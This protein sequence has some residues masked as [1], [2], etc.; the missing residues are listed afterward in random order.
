MDSCPRPLSLLL[1]GLLV[2]LW[3]VLAVGA[4][5]ARPPQGGIR[6][7]TVPGHL[8]LGADREAEVRIELEPEATGLELFASSGEVGP[9]TQVKPGV[10]RATYVPPR[11]RLPLEVILVALA[12]GPRGTLDGWSVLPL[13]GQGEA[14]VRTR[15]GA[16]VTLQVG[17]QSFGPVHADAKGLARIPVAVPPGVHEAFFG[18]RRIDLGVPPQPFLH[19]VAERREVRADR[20]ETVVIRLYSLKPGA[21]S[22]RPGDFSVS[23]GTLSAPAG[24]EPGVF[25]L[26][27]TVPPGPA[28]S[29]ELKGSVTRDR[30]GAVHV[31]LT[32]VPGPARHFVMRVDHEELVASEEVR[33][34]VEVSA[35]DAAGNPT[36]AG[37]RLESDFAGEGALTERQAGEYA[38]VFHLTPR[39]GTREQVVLRLLAEG[40]SAPVLTRTLKL[41]SAAPARVTVQPLQ[42][43]LMADGRSEAVWRIS[44][45]DRFGN[46]VREPWPEAML[47]R[48]L[49]STLLSKMPGTYELRYVPPAARVDHLSALDVRVGEVHGRGTLQLLRRR[50]VLLVAPRVGLVTNLGDVLAPSAGLRLE[51]WPMPQWPAVG[52]LLDTGYLGFSRTGGQAAPGFM[53]R[54]EWFDTTLAVGLRTL[55]E[56][57]LQGWVAMGPSVAR[58]RSRVMWGEGPALEEGTWVLGAQA[59]VGAGLPLVRGQPFLEARFSWFDDPSLRVLRGALWG[60]GLHVGYRLELF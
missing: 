16:P 1:V 49:A 39:F 29:L 10:F 38:G 18:K 13:W 56:K 50:P 31:R 27:W 53:G 19:A 26:R 20:E 41:R 54:N 21:M 43:M 51:A 12:R 25:L 15:A 22:P 48:E 44:V 9:V 46:P 4:E 6:I 37:L 11:Q 14:E 34:A 28:G 24:L 58:V 36:P 55:R 3:P 33:V 35:R 59:M 32:A 60:G 40:T 52:L 30:Q 42:P 47:A 8:L 5:A 2:G 7:Q 17:G 23:R 57:G 45:E